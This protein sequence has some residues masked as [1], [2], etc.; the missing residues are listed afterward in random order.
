MRLVIDRFEGNF[1]ICENDNM[2]II[3]IDKSKLP[4]NAKEGSIIEDK[5]ELY[6]LLEKETEDRNKRIK[7][8]MDRLWKS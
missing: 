7:E 1:A 8:K 5:E 2:E 3:H 4:A 6:I